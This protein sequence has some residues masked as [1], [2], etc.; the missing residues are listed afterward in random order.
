MVNRI[1]RWLSKVSSGENDLDG[2]RI[3]HQ[4]LTALR[5]KR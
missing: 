5:L 4:P 2:A 3:H 1:R